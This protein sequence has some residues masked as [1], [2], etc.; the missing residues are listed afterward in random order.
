VRR[1]CCWKRDRMATPTLTTHSS[2]PLFN[3]IK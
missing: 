1:P 3:L 2:E